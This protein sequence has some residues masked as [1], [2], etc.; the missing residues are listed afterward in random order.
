[1]K[2]K[3]TKFNI[4]KMQ[5][6]YA[7]TKCQNTIEKKLKIWLKPNPN[8]YFDINENTPYKAK[9]T[10]FISKTCLTSV[11]TQQLT[12]ISKKNK[13]KNSLQIL[14]L[15]TYIF[16]LIKKIMYTMQTQDENN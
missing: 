11:H 15:D 3:K 13:N 12:N 10:K 9:I 2:I 14:K 1:M 5:N 4:I 16:E 8:T 7:C 6:M